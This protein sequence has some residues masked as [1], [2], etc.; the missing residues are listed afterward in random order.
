MYTKHV[1]VYIYAYYV[2]WAVLG[3]YTY[4]LI[5]LFTSSFYMCDYLPFIDEEAGAEIS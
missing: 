3:F 2:L 5:Q 1:C 4:D